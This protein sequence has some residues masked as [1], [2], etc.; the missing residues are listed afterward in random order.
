[1]AFVVAWTEG[2]E[3]TG[4]DVKVA[5]VFWAAGLEGVAFVRLL[6][7]AEI[8]VVDGAGGVW[9]L[10]ETLSEATAAVFCGVDAGVEMDSPVDELAWFVDVT[11]SVVDCSAPDRSIKRK[12]NRKRKRE[13]SKTWIQFRKP[14]YQI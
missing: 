10:I 11:E 14:L 1:M 4:L 6:V 12:K 8:E 5:V 9:E 13:N 7:C 2:L 3:E